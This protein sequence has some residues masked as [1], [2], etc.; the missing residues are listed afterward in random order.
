MTVTIV[1]STQLGA[2]FQCP[3]CRRLFYFDTDYIKHKCIALKK[4]FSKFKKY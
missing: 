4:R 1:N 3:L 2:T